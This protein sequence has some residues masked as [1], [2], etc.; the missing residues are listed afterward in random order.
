MHLINDV[1]LFCLGTDDSTQ[2]ALFVRT[3]EDAVVVV[4]EAA[5]SPILHFWSLHSPARYCLW[6][7]YRWMLS[8]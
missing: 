4:K 5:F 8:S 7:T 1:V 2:R 6:W 3:H